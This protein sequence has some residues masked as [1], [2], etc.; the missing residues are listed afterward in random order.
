LVMERAVT[1]PRGGIEQA[2]CGAFDHFHS[3]AYVAV[4][5]EILI[6]RQLR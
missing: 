1:M 3:I 4:L 2:A 6:D 5:G